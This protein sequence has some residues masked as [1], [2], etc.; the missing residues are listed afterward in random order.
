MICDN[1]ELV[2]IHIPR[3][4]GHSIEHFLGYE[5]INMRHISIQDYRKYTVA[6]KKWYNKGGKAKLKATALFNTPRSNSPQATEHA[7]TLEDELKLL[8]I[9]GLGMIDYFNRAGQ[10]NSGGFCPQLVP[11]KPNYL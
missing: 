2:F 10:D 9:N 1:E 5:S 7:V 4:A 11:T 8:N 6:F 3:C